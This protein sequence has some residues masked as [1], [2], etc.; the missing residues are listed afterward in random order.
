[1]SMDPEFRERALLNFYSAERRAGS[2]P[3]VANER[4]GEFAKRLD[5]IY[6]HDLEAVK[7]CMENSK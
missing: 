6:E 2:C 7:Q 5:A 4:M 3:L 1:M